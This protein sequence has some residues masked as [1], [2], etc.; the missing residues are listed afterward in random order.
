M[1]TARGTYGAPSRHHRPGYRCPARG[2]DPARDLLTGAAA[3]TWLP[4]GQPTRKF[5]VAIRRTLHRRGFR[6][7]INVKKLQG[8]PDVVLPR[9]LAVI[10]VRDCF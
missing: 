8:K 9:Y 7:R 6:C 5:E 4:P 1:D 3:G 10:M 2:Y